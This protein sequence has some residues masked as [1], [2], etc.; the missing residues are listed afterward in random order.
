MGHCYCLIFYKEGTVR[1]EPQGTGK[2]SVERYPR[3]PAV[4]YKSLFLKAVTV[5]LEKWDMWEKILQK[6]SL[7]QEHGIWNILR[8]SSEIEISL[9]VQGE[10]TSI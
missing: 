5:I 6:D 3:G 2:S 7:N 4:R 8:K 1:H 9:E 10:L